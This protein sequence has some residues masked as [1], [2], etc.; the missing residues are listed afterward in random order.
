MAWDDIAA[1]LQGARAGVATF[2]EMITAV[3]TLDELFKRKADLT[4]LPEGMRAGIIQL[5]DKVISAQSTHSAILARLDELE[6][7]VMKMDRFEK[8]AARYELAATKAG[9]A[10]YALKAE[11]DRGEPHHCLCPNC[12]ADR[13]KSIL[14]P[15]GR[16]LEC[17]H[18][19]AR[20]AN[21]PAP[22]PRAV[23]SRNSW[24]DR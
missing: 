3:R 4:E 22:P 21:L 7:E 20:Y 23:S 19:K 17:P 16:R 18:C 24:L 12:Y 10:V 15:S 2:G 1:I 6:Q 14:Q 11:D 8:E 5:Q 13:K 9:A